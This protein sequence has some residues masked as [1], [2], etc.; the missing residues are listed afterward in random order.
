VFDEA[1][2]DR[3]RRR[4]KTLSIFALGLIALAAT[5]AVVV[6]IRAGETAVHL[7]ELD[8]PADRPP[9]AYEL[10]LI[11]ASEGFNDAQRL[12][13]EK[14][15]ADLDT[16]I[17]D[18]AKVAVY[19]LDGRS[20]S[21]L[22]GPIFARCKPPSG[23]TASE[24]TQNPARLARAWRASFHEP[25]QR[26]LASS[27]AQLPSAESPIMALVQKAVLA[28]FPANPTD[29]PRRIVVISDL[30]EHT[31]AY[32]QYGAAPP[33]FAVFVEQRF[34]RHLH[35]DLT[36]I[37]VEVLYVSRPGQEKVQG[38]RHLD[39]W[40]DYFVWLGVGPHRLTITRVPG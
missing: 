13:L 40:K 22:P 1:P 12:F 4:Q 18:H 15:F 2:S 31:R 21:D 37:D 32:S 33:G 3:Q 26:A 5:A 7:G 23:A 27:L 24:W 19:V 30:L 29:A 25:L 14:F 28:E 36:G 20:G 8:C 39:F 35:V 17:P 10:V 38:T 34:A 6:R 11:D 16:A 9:P